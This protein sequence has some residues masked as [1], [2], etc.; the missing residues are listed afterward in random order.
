[1]LN[2]EHLN[3][4]GCLAMDWNWNG[5]GTW[6]GMEMEWNGCLRRG[7]VGNG[8]GELAREQ[9]ATS[10]AFVPEDSWNWKAGD[11]LCEL[12]FLF[13]RLSLGRGM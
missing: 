11:A 1:L 6:N 9:R 2:E 4:M 5:D 12:S 7:E 3:R 10:K 13:V 8:I